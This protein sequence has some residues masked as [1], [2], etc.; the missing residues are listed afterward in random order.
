ME[1]VDGRDGP[2]DKESG[3]RLR[4]DEG[5]FLSLALVRKVTECGGVLDSG[6]FSLL[7]MCRNL[8]QA[9]SPQGV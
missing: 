2:D 4:S 6:G 5:N 8:P 9:S 3:M 7:L 1:K